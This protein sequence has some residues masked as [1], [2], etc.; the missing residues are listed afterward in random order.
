MMWQRLLGE[1]YVKPEAAEGEWEA[2]LRVSIR[3]A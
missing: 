1:D 3:K 2:N